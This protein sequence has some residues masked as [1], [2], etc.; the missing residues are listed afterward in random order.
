MLTASA[1]RLTCEGVVQ[2]GSRLTLPRESSVLPALVPCTQDEDADVRQAALGLLAAAAAQVSLA[3]QLQVLT[4]L[5]LLLPVV[6]SRPASTC[7]CARV[8]SCTVICNN[9]AAPSFRWAGG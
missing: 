5:G 3:A 6:S 7:S 2:E 1:W 4:G 8:C 9:S